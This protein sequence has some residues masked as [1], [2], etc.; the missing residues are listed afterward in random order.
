MPNTHFATVFDVAGAKNQ[1]VIHAVIKQSDRS[2]ARR[3]IAKNPGVCG[4][5]EFLAIHAHDFAGRLAHEQIDI[6]EVAGHP[7]AFLEEMPGPGQCPT[8]TWRLELG[9]WLVSFDPPSLTGP[10]CPRWCRRG[11]R[12]SLYCDRTVLK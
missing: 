10:Q 4:Q 8:P 2:S 12:P 6:V 1:R 11:P 7:Q 9:H 3:G 5:F